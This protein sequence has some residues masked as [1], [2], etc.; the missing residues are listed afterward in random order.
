MNPKP[1]IELSLIIPCFN[2]ASVLPALQSRLRD[3]LNALGLSWEVIFI[4]DGS[5]DST[6]E[7][8]SKMHQTEPRFKVIALSRNF[9]HQAALCAGLAR[10]SGDAVGILDADLQDP[11]E[12]FRTCLAKLREGYDVIYAVR[13]HRK[14]NALKRLAYALFY[15]LL[16]RVSEV[17]IPLDSG[18]FCLMH[19]RVV[20]VLR[21]MPERNVFLR[22]MRAWTGFRQIGLEYE[23]NARAA[24]QTKYSFRKLLGLAG[25]GVFAFSVL[26]LRIATFLGF[27]GVMLASLA[28]VLVLAWRLLGFRFMGHTAHELP[29]WAGV[30]CL[31]LFLSGIQFLILGCLGEYLGRIYRE[32]KQ[33]PRWIARDSLGFDGPLN[34]S[35]EETAAY[36]H[37]LV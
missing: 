2:E 12:L 32:V 11:P 34:A 33:R 36:D 30:V 3:C 25:D 26:P 29:G 6:F 21:T 37:H 10:A 23:R 7:E 14:E 15:R 35:G 24:G 17:D 22:G 31:V 18:D 8:L 9:G 5:T 4:D 27:A 16:R 28:G 13:R 20:E 1:H 19:H